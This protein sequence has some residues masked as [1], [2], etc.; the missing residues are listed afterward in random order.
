MNVDIEK[1]YA[2]TRDLSNI[3][4]NY[5]QLKSIT[6]KVFGYGAYDTRNEFLDTIKE[7][8]PDLNLN[9]TV[10]YDLFLNFCVQKFCVAKQTQLKKL[11]REES[12]G[13]N[14]FHDK[15]IIVLSHI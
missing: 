6:D 2:T 11:G 9:Y 10:P 8:F 3:K 1:L 7:N 14:L 12:T 13:L 15:Y 4:L 5:H